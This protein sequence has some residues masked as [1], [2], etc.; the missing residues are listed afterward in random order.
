MKELVVTGLNHRTAPVALRERFA[1]PASQLPEV[2]RRLRDHEL[3]HECVLLSTC[4]RVE[5]YA[6]ETKSEGGSSASIQFFLEHVPA[7]A[8]EL[9]PHIYHYRR[10]EAVSHLF[11]VTASLD[12]MIV[13]EPQ[14]L[15]QVKEAYAAAQRAGTAGPIFHRLFTQALHV[16]KRVRHETDIGRLAVSV[17]YAAVELAKRIFDDVE[18]RRVVVIGRGEMSELVLRHLEKAG[19]A[20]FVVVGRCFGHACQFARRFENAVA[21]PYDQTLRF[22]DDADIVIAS[23]RAPHF[24]VERDAVAELMRRRR[25]RLLLMI[26]ISVPRVIDE[27][28]N[29]LDNVYLFNID[30]LQ[31]IVQN[32]YRLRLEEAEKAQRLIKSEVAEFLQWLDSRDLVPTIQAFRRRMEDLLA[33]ELERALRSC[34]SW[35]EQQKQAFESFGRALIN[36]ICHSPISRLKS[37]Q[38]PYDAAIFRDALR[39][40]FDLSKPGD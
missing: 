39:A 2:L 34:P 23:T 4:N 3:I 29:D 31:D 18:G 9:L 7:P 25:N 20:E 40:L 28:V 26:D 35:D 1:V 15:G 21:R 8:H 19:I 6:L 16:G 33:D 38:D 24:L 12:S 37:Q 13:G 5:L 14:I 22:L 17:P 11:T 32:N 10:E 36:K 30:H 27:A